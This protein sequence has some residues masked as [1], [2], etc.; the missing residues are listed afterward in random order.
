MQTETAPFYRLSRIEKNPLLAVSSKVPT[1]LSGTDTRHS[2]LTVR[3]PSHP[4]WRHILSFS[5]IPFLL[6]LIKK[7]FLFPAFPVIF[8]QLPFLS[9]QPF[10]L[11]ECQSV[12][13]PFQGRRSLPVPSGSTDLS[14]SAH[15]LL[16]RL[17]SFCFLMVINTCCRTKRQTR[18][19]TCL[20]GE[21]QSCP[22]P[23]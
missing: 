9:V 12:V 11:H 7:L 5:A 16:F 20:K 18:N 23:Y 3:C 2:P 15:S 21:G 10:R 13:A 1:C 6:N 8:F 14:S 17:T 4:K 19:N 22:A